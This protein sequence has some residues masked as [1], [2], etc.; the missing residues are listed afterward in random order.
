MNPLDFLLSRPGDRIISQARY[1]AG[2]LSLLSF[3]APLPIVSFL[4][5][6]YP[7]SR[8]PFFFF[9]LGTA[10][11]WILGWFLFLALDRRWLT[12]RRFLSLEMMLRIV[13]GLPFTVMAASS[14]PHRYWAYL[15]FA[16][17]LLGR[18]ALSGRA[19]AIY[20]DSLFLIAL[21]GVLFWRGEGTLDRADWINC[22]FFFSVT[23]LQMVAQEYWIKSSKKSV[24]G[25]RKRGLLR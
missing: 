12:M 23:F 16:P 4:V 14:A 5:F 3:L 8:F 21:A 10:L 1:Y 24:R 20:Y 19:G 15:R 2:L 7:D 18:R 22:L 9:L 25:G 6:L 11:E 17:M 13:F